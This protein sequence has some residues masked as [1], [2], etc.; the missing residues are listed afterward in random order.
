MAEGEHRKKENAWQSLP[1]SNL[2]PET[3]IQTSL[4]KVLLM[5]TGWWRSSL[6]CLIPWLMSRRPLAGK[7]L[8]GVLL[9]LTGGCARVGLRH[10]QCLWQETCLL[11]GR[12]HL[13][14]LVPGKQ[15]PPSYSI[16]LAPCTG[17]AITLCLLAKEKCLLC[18]AVESICQEKRVDLEHRGNKLITGQVY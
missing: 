1:T 16:F 3:Y 2:L 14:A 6:G 8:S 9:K 5:L 7:L 15:S 17:K 12:W 4:Q 10:R 11:V 18:P 13:A